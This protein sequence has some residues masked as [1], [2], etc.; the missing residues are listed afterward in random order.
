MLQTFLF[1]VLR[2]LS[3][4]NNYKSNFVLET[5]TTYKFCFLWQNT[6]WV[7]DI[8]PNIFFLR[9]MNMQNMFLNW[10]FFSIA[11]VFFSSS[12]LVSLEKMIW[13]TFLT[14]LWTHDTKNYICKKYIRDSNPY[15]V[16][17]AWQQGRNR[18]SRRKSELLY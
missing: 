4:W 12:T 2:D 18:E 1:Y 3:K 10:V 8:W 11:L 14:F 9:S 16:G 13:H 6:K 7:H 17:Q 15:L 5:A